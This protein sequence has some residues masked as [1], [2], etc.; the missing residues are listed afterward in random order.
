MG[1]YKT[2]WATNRALQN[3]PAL[4]S[5]WP[6]YRRSSMCLLQGIVSHGVAHAAAADVDADVPSADGE[7]RAD[8]L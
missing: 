5:V 1:S 6:Q 2:N 4:P 7:V 3:S 8:V